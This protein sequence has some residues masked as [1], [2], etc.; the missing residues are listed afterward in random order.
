MADT[1]PR[2]GW[3]PDRRETTDV[4]VSTS[5]FD[6]QVRTWA[7][8]E[9]LYRSRGWVLAAHG[10]R[11]VE[12]VLFAESQ[13]RI[14][15]VCAGV[16]YVNFD[17]EPPSITFIDPV[18]REPARPFAEPL[19]LDQNGKPVSLLVNH[20]LLGRPFW[21][22]PGNLE[23]HQH[24]QH[25]GDP[26]LTDPRAT[27]QGDLAVIAERLWQQSVRH[28]Q[29]QFQVAFNVQPVAQVDIAGWLRESDVASS[30]SNSGGLD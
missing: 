15:A 28:R 26:W 14:V 1:L 17:I 20:P 29:V 30:P 24:P 16:D 12:L 18:T 4:V 27:R 2:P 5:K 13:P 3:C 25:D 22:L 21:C 10:D 19:Q 23:F 6:R 8:N 9:D 7:T 11:W